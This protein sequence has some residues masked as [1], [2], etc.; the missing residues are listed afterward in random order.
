MFKFHTIFCV[1]Q[2]MTYPNRMQKKGVERPENLVLFLHIQSPVILNRKETEKFTS[3]CMR[4]VLK[5]E[6]K[7]T[8]KAPNTAMHVT[9]GKQCLLPAFIFFNGRS[10]YLNVSTSTEYSFTYHRH[11]FVLLRGIYLY[12]HTVT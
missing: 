5:T 9:E 7:G 4:T 1:L 2:T 8:L 3:V 12:S 6:I 11:L 10:L